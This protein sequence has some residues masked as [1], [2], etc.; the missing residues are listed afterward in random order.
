MNELNLYLIGFLLALL[1]ALIIYTIKDLKQ[2]I[3]NYRKETQEEIK[4]L[5]QL[6]FKIIGKEKIN[7]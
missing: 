1:Q 2:T 6:I 3:N 4:E 5:R 7:V